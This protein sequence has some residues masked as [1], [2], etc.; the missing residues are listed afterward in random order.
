M[1]TVQE[2]RAEALAKAPGTLIVQPADARYDWAN[3]GVNTRGLVDAE[4]A[5]RFRDTELRAAPDAV[6]FDGEQR[7]QLDGVASTTDQPYRMWDVFGEYDEIIG[8][9]AFDETLAAQPDVAFLTNHGGLTMARSVGKTPS[10]E[11][12]VGPT[13]LTA[14][15]FVNPQR[16]DVATLVHAIRDGDMTEM[17]FAFR[18]ED[19][20]WS[21][22]YDT[23]TIT[24]VNLHRGDVSAVNYG[25]NPNTSI[26]VRTA[27]V[28]DDLEHLSTEAARAAL[29]R[30]Q[31]RSDLSATVIDLASPLPFE[32][33]GDVPQPHERKLAP[34]KV[35]KPGPQVPVDQ[36]ADTG[37]S[38]HLVRTEW[39][40]DE[41]FDADK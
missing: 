8:R 24:R 15:A 7:V 25:A 31:A 9:S 41:E 19:G 12:G 28:L 26:T 17:S 1:G 32:I 36:R 13:G 22:D 23:F 10:L 35:L 18:I 3:R 40:L 21:E 4:C 30:L 11:L 6:E 14:R 27:D 37:R 33:C 39:L 29:A 38:V 5:R 16:P 20:E 2:R 34:S